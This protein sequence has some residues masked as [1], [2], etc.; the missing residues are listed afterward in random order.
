MSPSLLNGLGLLLKQRSID[1]V[2]EFLLAFLQKQR[3]YL[4]DVSAL[5]P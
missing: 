3:S 5:T 2:C 4:T 1:S